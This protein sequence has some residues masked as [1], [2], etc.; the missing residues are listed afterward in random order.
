MGEES[1]HYSITSSYLETSGE[2]TEFVAI[3]EFKGDS[4]FSSS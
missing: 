1:L 3:T 4:T 2:I